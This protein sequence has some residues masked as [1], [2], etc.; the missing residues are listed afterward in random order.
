MMTNMTQ[1]QPS[2]KAVFWVA[3]GML[4]FQSC[5]S[6]KVAPIP[7]DDIDSDGVEDAYTEGVLFYAPK[8]YLLVVQTDKGTSTSIVMLPDKTQPRT[9]VWDNGW[10]G[11]AKPKFSLEGGWNLTGFESVSDSGVSAALTA[12]GG[13]AGMLSLSADNT[14]QGGYQLIPLTWN[15]TNWTP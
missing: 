15:G 12:L 4:C 3:L 9:I 7:I 8:P 10:F 11:T 5:A 2:A 14:S 6:V 1:F 13:V